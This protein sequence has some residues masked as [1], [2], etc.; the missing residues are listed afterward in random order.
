MESLF[1]STMNYSH[2]NTTDFCDDDSTLLDLRFASEDTLT[3]YFYSQ[4]DRLITLVFYPIS[5]VFGLVANISFLLVLFQVPDMRTITNAYLGNLAFADIVSTCSMN[6]LILLSYL[7]SP[8][9][10]SKAYTSSLECAI[11]SNVDW[12]S[13]LASIA[14]VLIMSVERYL[15]ICKPLYHR[16]II[17]KGRTVK[18]I[19][20]A[21]IFGLTYSCV[22]VAPR[23]YVLAKT[24][25]LWPTDTFYENVPRVIHSLYPLHPLYKYWSNIWQAIPFTLAM[26]ATVV[27]YVLIIKTLSKRISQFDEGNNQGRQISKDRDNVARLLI[28]NGT[29]FFLANVPYYVTRI[30][31]ALLAITDNQVGYQMTPQQFGALYRVAV[32]LLTLNSCINSVIYNLTNQRYRRAFVHVFTCRSFARKT[33][34]N[35]SHLSKPRRQSATDNIS[36]I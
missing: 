18:L 13:H 30:N 7:K 1:N 15:G 36:N 16:R 33:P 19:I 23:Y 3:E 5:F 2:S 28:A 14:L 6:Y 25:V 34:K 32:C 26:I 12:T 9:V 31:N 22:F 10:K 20:F 11:N 24:C 17:T 35:K 29:V 21:W 27:M 4:Q 8:Q